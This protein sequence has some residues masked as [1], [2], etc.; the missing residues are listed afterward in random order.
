[1]CDP[2]VVVVVLD[3]GAGWWIGWSASST[4]GHAR[5]DAG[6]QGGAED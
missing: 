5:R 3:T 2:N 4:T 6:T 1:L